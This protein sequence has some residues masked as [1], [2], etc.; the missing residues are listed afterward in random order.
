MLERVLDDFLGNRDEYGGKMHCSWEQTRL[1]C[2]ECI[3]LATVIKFEFNS[4]V[5]IDF[6]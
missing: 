3:L 5:N 6:N 2:S 4:Q 1:H